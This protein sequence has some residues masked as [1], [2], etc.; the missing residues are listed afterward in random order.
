MSQQEKDTRQ[1]QDTT[2]SGKQERTT[3]LQ[4]RRRLLKAAGMAPVIYTVSGAG[5]AQ[6]MT[7]AVCRSKL[8]SQTQT[9]E[10]PG[11]INQNQLK[12]GDKYELVCKGNRCEDR[13]DGYR[14]SA[15]E[16]AWVSALC[17]DSVISSVS[18]ATKIV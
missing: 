12:D 13:Y 7:S 11:N 15:D 2:L 5:A 10:L 17:W 4:N 16:G 8:G 9:S 6:A 18:G 3:T 1:G 14:Y